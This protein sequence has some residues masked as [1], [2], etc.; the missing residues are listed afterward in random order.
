MEFPKTRERKKQENFLSTLSKLDQLLNLGLPETE[1]N[2]EASPE[3][4][5]CISTLLDQIAL[6]STNPRTKD[7]ATSILTKIYELERNSDT[8][9]LAI[10]LSCV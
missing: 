2:P 5:A 1:L 4:L 7:M 9:Q 10:Q 8:G 3:S 6:R